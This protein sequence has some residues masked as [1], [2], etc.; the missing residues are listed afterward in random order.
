MIPVVVFDRLG[1]VSSSL[2][3]V[4][5]SNGRLKIPA[6]HV[7]L[8]KIFRGYQVL[9]SI[10]LWALPLWRFVIVQYIQFLGL[11]QWLV[12]QEWHIL[13]ERLIRIAIGLP[14]RLAIR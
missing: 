11:L 2:L 13:W 1:L 8:C 10:C 7:C 14:K 9:G 12:Q 6:R 3:A 5:G 4:S